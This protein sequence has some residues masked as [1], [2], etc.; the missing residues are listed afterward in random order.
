MEGG[1]V[2]DEV[3]Q[4]AVPGALL[5]QPEQLAAAFVPRM[6]HQRRRQTIQIASRT[7]R[8]FILLWPSTRSVKT[9]GISTSRNPFF[10]A[11]KLISIWKA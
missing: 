9:I 3:A 2:G 6:A 5:G 10:Q 8:L 4:H 7:M 1:A 11:R